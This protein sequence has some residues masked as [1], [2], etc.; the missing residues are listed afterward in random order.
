MDYW[1]LDE[2][3]SDEFELFLQNLNTKLALNVD[4][5]IDK[6]VNEEFNNI[7]YEE[8]RK[9]WINRILMCAYLA[10]ISN[11]IVA[12]EFLYNLYYSDEYK[13]ELLKLI[14]KKSIYEYYV[15]LKE[16]GNGLFSKNVIEDIVNNIEKK[17]VQNV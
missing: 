6:M 10:L 11:N 13:N 16:T 3:Y 14:L 2:G 17:W 5:D 8:E 1:F 15:N 4:F 12:T 7:F 9:I